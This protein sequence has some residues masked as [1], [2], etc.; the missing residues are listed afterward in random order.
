MNITLNKIDPVNATVTID[1]VKEDYANEVGK[2]IKDIR[3]NAVIPGFRKGMVPLSRIQQMYGKSIMFEEINKLVSDKLI[4]YIKEE[5]LTLLG[6]PLPSDD[7]QELL[8]IDKQQ[9]FSFIFDLGLA[10]DINIKL[11]KKDKL[12]YYS[13]EVTD[14]MLEK[15]INN[16]KANY[17]TYESVEEVEGKDM[18]KG[19]LTELDEN[20]EP[21]ANGIQH[22]DAVLMPNYM[23]DEEEKAKFMGAKVNATIVFN[24]FKAYNGNT[25]ELSSFLKIKKEEVNNYTSNF[26]L[27][28]KEITRYK[29]AEMNQELFD[30]V[31]E[32][33]TITTEEDF[34]ETIKRM[35]ARQLTPESDYKF[36]LDARKYL[37]DKAGE[38]I[39]PEAFLKRWLL[40]SPSNKRTPESIEADFPKIL[41]DLKFRLIQDQLSK[42]YG[43][44]VEEADIKEA[45]KEATLEQFAQ[46]GMN[47][48]PEHLLESYA[49][50]MLKKEE[51]IQ[52]LI[53]KTI[54]KK[55]IDVLKEKITL[56]PKT[57]TFEEFQKLFEEEKQ[58]VIEP[59]PQSSAD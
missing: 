20:N 26:S 32:P 16:Y 38:V 14:F 44:I 27:E 24:P 15:R 4:A 37:D 6:E 3:R 51:T 23:K 13:I 52:N 30:K 34:R 21:K 49:E 1:V 42:D 5:K 50:E 35:I 59:S 41:E 33:G 57:V 43:I 8:D 53:D 7:K 36:W 40:V 47:N 56:E 19:T 48:I 10:P 54:E 18:V 55:L 39:F 2:N 22:E 45:A 12:P 28:I 58:E 17:G 29:E 31:F 9:D 46:Y 25:A 11:S